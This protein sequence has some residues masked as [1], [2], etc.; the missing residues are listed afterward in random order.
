M[1]PNTKIVSGSFFWSEKMIS[2]RISGQAAPT[3]HSSRST[4]SQSNRSYNTS[5]PLTRIKEQFRWLVISIVTSR[6]YFNGRLGSEAAEA[7]RG[8]ATQPIGALLIISRAWAA[9]RRAAA[10]SRRASRLPT[11][12]RA[13]IPSLICPSS[14]V[15]LST[16]AVP[17][18]ASQRSEARRT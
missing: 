2:V 6:S 17:P 4:K 10:P 11:T 18:F 9:P 7:R 13:I 8:P 15:A 14:K 12:P 16:S 3:T 1:P 5:N